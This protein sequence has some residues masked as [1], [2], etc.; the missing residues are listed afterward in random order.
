MANLTTT[1]KADKPQKPTLSRRAWQIF[2]EGQFRW[3]NAM[4]QYSDH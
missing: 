3:F 1:P 4:R 2:R